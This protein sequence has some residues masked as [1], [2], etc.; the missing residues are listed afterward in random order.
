MS[1]SRYVTLNAAGIRFAQYV[2]ENHP[3]GDKA[4]GVMAIRCHQGFLSSRVHQDYAVLYR[5]LGDS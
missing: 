1:Y 2:K 5:T 4:A 3:L